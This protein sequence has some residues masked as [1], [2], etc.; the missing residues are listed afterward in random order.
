MGE[1][2]RAGL[3]IFSGQTIGVKLLVPAAI[4]VL[5][6]LA[7]FLVAVGGFGSLRDSVA[8]M[9]RLQGGLVR[10]VSDLQ[11]Q[12]YQ[13]HILL[14]RA[15]A[16]AGN[17]RRGSGSPLD[18][19]LGSLAERIASAQSLVGSIMSL[20]GAAKVAG[21]SLNGF[22]AAFTD[23]ADWLGKAPDSLSGK[24]APSGGFIA[25]ADEKFSALGDS[26]DKLTSVVR[27]AGNATAARARALVAAALL[28][29]TALIVAA[30]VFLILLNVLT[31]RSVTRPIARLVA[32]V[33][34]IGGGDLGA[35]FGEAGGRDELSRMARSVD[36]LVDGL[37][38]L[39]GAV[40]RRL[41][42]LEGAGRDL[43]ATM[44]ETGAAVVQINANISNTKGQLDEQSSAVEEVSTAIEELARSVDALSAMISD[45]SSVISQS[46]A[47][48]EEMIANVQSVASTAERTGGESDLSLE[49]CAAGKA[50]IDEVSDA[51]A[52]IVRLSQ[53][54]NE[55]AEVITEIADR[56]NL[57]A[58]NAAI[59]AAHAGESGKGFAVVADEI[60]KLAEQSTAQ[61]KD[62]S[63]DLGRVSSSIE[64]V[65]GA[66][67]SAVD[68]FGAILRRATGVGDS[69]REIGN[70]MK[71]Q[72][73]GGKQVLEAL[74]RLHN[75]TSEISSGS[76]EMAAGNAS[77]LGQVERLRNV[78]TVVVRNNLEI[79]QG[80][81]EINE[82]ISNTVELS[83]RNASLIDEVKASVDRF[84]AEGA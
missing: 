58:M 63:S 53:N 12:C 80:T 48:V 18:Q 41:D 20:E 35:K 49:E 33:E 46:S 81:R 73:V 65:R 71:E 55:A 9:Q 25:T 13:A 69:V 37:R 59:E 52:S 10:K 23:Y 67:L 29:V 82:A 34:R 30:V 6:F 36:D 24:G 2:R 68:A 5:A 57:L 8:E 66:S 54:L 15:Q 21:E 19:A 64:L 74:S 43:A 17:P 28:Q 72:L 44:E 60:R 39:V 40:K 51:V 79:N 32:L 84:K 47:S 77:I 11:G 83:S 76:V 50:R 3:G 78:N 14:Y 31:A 42:S 45:Q 56:T 16:A 70:A 62:I 27:E 38:D 7:V 75:I 61:S 1:K 26:F 22:V 4:T